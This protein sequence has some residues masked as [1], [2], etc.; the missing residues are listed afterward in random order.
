MRALSEIHKFHPRDAFWYLAG[1]YS[2]SE[3][4]NHTFHETA[5]AQLMNNKVWV[6]SPIVH[7]HA[8]NKSHNQPT[9]FEYWQ[10]YNGA[11]I[12]ACYGVIVLAIDGWKTSKGVQWEIPFVVKNHKP[13]EFVRF[14]DG[15]LR[16]D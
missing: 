12:L 4:I 3:D 13:L 8:M 11:G 1:P 5:T 7:Q 15:E 2:G 10:E 6:Y 16:L 9:S 14:Y